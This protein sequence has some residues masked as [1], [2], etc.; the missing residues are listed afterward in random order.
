MSTDTKELE[1]VEDKKLVR[2]YTY[3][4]SPKNKLFMEYYL[5]PTS[6]TFG[7]VFRSGIKAGFSKTYAT[8]MLNVAP[9]WLLSYIEKTEFTPE[10]LNQ[11]L[12]KLALKAN[13]SR[14]PDDTRLKAIELMMKSKGMIDKQGGVS[15]T[16]V[17]P[18]LGG[19]SVNKLTPATR[20]EPIEGEI[21]PDVDKLIPED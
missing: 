18:I 1:V 2:K 9:K 11:L 21:V 10:H 6:E 8:N 12:Q 3:R 4:P 19:K 15:F 5:N 17:Q 16:F 7:N 13:D 20:K 14:S